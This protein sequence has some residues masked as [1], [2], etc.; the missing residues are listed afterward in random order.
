[1]I[2]VFIVR[3]THIK[4]LERSKKLFEKSISK[5]LD[6]LT[7]KIEDIALF[8][9]QEGFKKSIKENL[10][11]TIIQ[12]WHSKYLGNF[13][14]DLENNQLLFEYRDLIIDRK[15]EEYFL[16]LFRNIKTRL[17]IFPKFLRQKSYI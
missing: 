15:K 5:V 8:S 16:N 4:N 10:I 14:D 12:E 7:H 2:I 1:M 17:K 9:S 6:D 11:T 3:N 13:Q